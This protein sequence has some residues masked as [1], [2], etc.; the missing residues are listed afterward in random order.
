MTKAGAVLAI[1]LLALAGCA[2]KAAPEAAV[3]KFFDDLAAGRTKAAYES[4]A[5]GFQ[6]QQSFQRFDTTVRE[7][8]LGNLASVTWSAPEVNGRSAKVRGDFAPKAGPK[9]PLVVTLND[10][11]G[12]WRVAALKSPRDVQT[13][14]VQ[15]R[16]S[17][18]GKAPD[19]VELA[20]RQS[21]PDEA[22]VRKL[23]LDAMLQFDEAVRQKSF[24][25]FYTK[26][27]RAWQNQITEQR[28]QRAF[29]GFIDGQVEFRGIREVEAVLDGPAQVS[30]EGLLLVSG[31]YPAKLHPVIFALKFMYELPK[32]R[33]FGIDVSLAK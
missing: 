6:A 13:G 22:T 7:M 29:Q 19:F 15:N 3:K 21:V 27:A 33:L 18:V 26:T 23:T 32:W 5:F 16:F 30:T 2:K 10:E 24:A 20:R 1:V 9:F 11:S 28:L 14:L 8:G 25:D 12:D 17:A 31:H 4:A